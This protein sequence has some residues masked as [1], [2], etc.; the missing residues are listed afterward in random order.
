MLSVAQVLEMT[1][2]D[3]Q[4]ATWINPGFVA[5]V[6]E[7][8]STKAKSS[9]KPMHICT[10]KDT[11]IDAEIML[12]VFRPSV[13]FSQGDTIEV[14]GQGLRRTEYNGAEQATMGKGTEIH[15]VR[16]GG[17][18]RPSNGPGT[19]RQAQPTQQA[20]EESFENAAPVG[21]TS[22]PTNHR[23]EA[24][25]VD[26]PNPVNGQTVGMAVKAAV[27]ILIHNQTPVDLA[28]LQNN[29]EAIASCLIAASR[30]LE[31]GAVAPQQH[32]EDV[33]F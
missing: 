1:P 22:A 11:Q 2:G 3:D 25:L 29:V 30:R 10:L 20:Q 21:R 16:K 27:D 33:H 23:Q 14:T 13:P 12:T 8:K 26:R 31:S 4:N 15:V 7:I 6:S 9:G 5:V 32:A 28:K 17:Q 18:S 19:A 24:N